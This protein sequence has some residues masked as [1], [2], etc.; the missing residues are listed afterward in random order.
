MNLVFNFQHFQITCIVKVKVEILSFP[1]ANVSNSPLSFIKE[2][3][4]F[5]KLYKSDVSKA[6]A[7]YFAAIGNAESVK[8]TLV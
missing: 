1:S 4:K 2:Y 3:S 8:M 6:K 7:K 5:N